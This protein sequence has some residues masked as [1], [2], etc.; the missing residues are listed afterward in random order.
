MNFRFCVRVRLFQWELFSGGICGP[1]ALILGN[2][3]SSSLMMVIRMVQQNNTDD[4]F[5][6]C[7]DDG[8]ATHMPWAMGIVGKKHFTSELSFQTSDILRSSTGCG[9]LCLITFWLSPIL[10]QTSHVSAFSQLW[11]WVLILGNRLSWDFSPNSYWH[12]RMDRRSVYPLKTSGSLSNH[13]VS[14]SWG[15][16]VARKSRRFRKFSY[17]FRRPPGKFASV[18]VIGPAPLGKLTGH[19]V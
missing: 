12:P 17:F 19:W 1:R 10:T 3:L 8:D 9:F 16:K 4:N 15:I 5:G 11:A 6:H 13:I 18:M 14:Q 7:D 2:R